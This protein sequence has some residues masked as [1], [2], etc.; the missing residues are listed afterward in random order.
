MN[1][2]YTEPIAVDLD[3]DGIDEIIAES[4]VYDHDLRFIRKLTSDTCATAIPVRQDGE[5]L[6]AMQ[7]WPN[8]GLRV[9]EV[10]VVDSRGKVRAS[11]IPEFPF[12]RLS[13]IHCD[14]GRPSRLI[15]AG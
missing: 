8:F 12:Y 11:W 10:R 6:I 2:T 14:G 5:L 4:C 15:A 7:I 9:D 1:G 3:G 13:A